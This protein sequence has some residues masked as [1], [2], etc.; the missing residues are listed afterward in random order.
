M[1]FMDGK[2]A[3]QVV[4]DYIEREISEYKKVTQQELEANGITLEAK[5]AFSRKPYYGMTGNF[6]KKTQNQQVVY[7]HKSGQVSCL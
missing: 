6:V 3:E 7:L 2:G 4:N 5:E 1:D